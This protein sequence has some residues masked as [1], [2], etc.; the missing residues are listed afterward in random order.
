MNE[1]DYVT[2][3]MKGKLQKSDFY[4]F[5]G[6]SVHED[7]RGELINLFAFCQ[8]ITDVSGQLTNESAQFL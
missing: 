1:K 6:G 4:H 8:P 3:K 2:D 5:L 7:H